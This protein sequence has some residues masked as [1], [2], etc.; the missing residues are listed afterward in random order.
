MA[1][2][3][4]EPQPEAAGFGASSDASAAG[5]ALIVAAGEA[6]AAGAGVMPNEKVPAGADAIEGGGALDFSISSSTAFTAACCVAALLCRNAAPHPPPVLAGAGAELVDAGD[7]AAG[8]SDA[9]GAGVRRLLMSEAVEAG[10]P[11][12]KSPAAGL[13][14]GGAFFSSISFCTASVAAA[15]A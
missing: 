11:N 8:A 4:A 10:A 3:N 14:A 2:R 15:A 5:A 6:L 9:A 13:L 7:E 12:E 1:E